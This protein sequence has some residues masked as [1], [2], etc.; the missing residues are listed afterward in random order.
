VPTKKKMTRRVKG[1]GEGWVACRSAVRVA[2]RMPRGVRD[3]RV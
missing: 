1:S 3:W 2:V